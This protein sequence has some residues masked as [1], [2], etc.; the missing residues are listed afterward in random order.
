VPFDGFVSLHE[1]I[2]QT[3]FIEQVNQ[4]VSTATVKTIIAIR[5]YGNIKLGVSAIRL[6]A[7]KYSTLQ[8]SVHQN[9]PNQLHQNKLT[10]K[11]ANNVS[12]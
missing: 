3:G 6:I 11:V 4:K 5:L 10:P 12:S 7:M 9:H 2:I 8:H 1:Q